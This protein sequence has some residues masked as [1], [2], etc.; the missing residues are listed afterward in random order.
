MVS[1]LRDHVLSSVVGS[2]T[3]RRGAAPGCGGDGAEPGVARRT[4]GG[5][6]RGCS[7]QAGSPSDG[8]LGIGRVKRELGS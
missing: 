7:G 5:P 4:A 2:L 6:G 1:L 3:K 8:F